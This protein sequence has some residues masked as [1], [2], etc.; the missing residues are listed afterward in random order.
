MQRISGQAWTYVGSDGPNVYWAI[1]EPAQRLSRDQGLLVRVRK[2]KYFRVG[3]ST[4]LSDRR[5]AERANDVW[6]LDFIYGETAAYHSPM[7]LTAEVELL[8]G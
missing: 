8:T 6:G 2:I 7:Y 1:H 3:A 4:I 5:G